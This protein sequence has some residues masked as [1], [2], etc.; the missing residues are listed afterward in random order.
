MVK[1]RFFDSLR[2]VG[3]IKMTG[4]AHILIARQSSVPEIPILRLGIAH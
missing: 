4:G 1:C 3:S 2:F